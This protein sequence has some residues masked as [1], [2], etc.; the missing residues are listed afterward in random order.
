MSGWIEALLG[1]VAVVCLLAVVYS[2]AIYPLVLFVVAALRQAARDAAFVWRKHDRRRAEAVAG[3]WPAVAIV[4]SAYD[5]ERHLA[6]RIDNLL[7]LDYPADR[8]RAYIGSDGSRDRTAEIL[9]QHGGDPRIRGFAF[10]LNRGKAEVLNDLVSRTDEPL[11]VFSDANTFFRPDALKRLVAAFADPAVGGVT[12]ELR[13]MG[14][15]GDNQD[16]LYWRVEQFL[17]FFES[18]LGALLGANGAIYAIRRTLWKPLARDTI[19]DDFC[20]AMNV[21]A[22]GARLVY[23]PRAWA[24]EDTPEHMGE[25]FHRRVRIGIGNFQALLRHPEYL[26]RTPPATRFAYVS[27]KVLRWIAPHLL[28]VALAASAVLA[29]GSTA[30]AAATLA[31]ALSYGGA[32]L[33]LQQVRRGRRLPRPLMLAAFLFALNWAFLVASWR[34]ASGRYSGAWGRTSR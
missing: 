21:A 13:L 34:Y 1:A 31:Q 33:A 7:A 15:D 18:R 4:I 14:N 3:D 12:G 2:Y 27:H 24:E 22:T 11:L 25:E 30:W 5:E 32:A 19:C 8:L 23:E 10:E 29:T 28:I 20:V 9:A 6:R 26:L 16:S 17:K